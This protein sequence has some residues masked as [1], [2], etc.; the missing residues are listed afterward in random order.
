VFYAQHRTHPCVALEETQGLKPL[1]G[2]KDVG[3]VGVA[4][5]EVLQM[6]PRE[7]SKRIWALGNKG[8]QS[9]PVVL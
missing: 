1:A 7:T 3:Y 6:Q 2:A 4:K 9:R 5:P 8:V